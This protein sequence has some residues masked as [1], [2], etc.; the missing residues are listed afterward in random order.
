M[1]LNAFNDIELGESPSQ[2]VAAVGQPYSINRKDS[3]TVEYEYIER[4][5]AGGRDLEDRRYIITIR[6]GKVVNKQVQYSSP[7]PY[8][9]DSYEMQTSQRN[10]A[11]PTNE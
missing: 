6:D 3:E 9:Y 8:L 10:T 11:M 5:K 2:V 1:N 4:I 7:A